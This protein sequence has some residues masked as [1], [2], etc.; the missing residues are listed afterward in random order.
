MRLILLI[1]LCLALV[2]AS[3]QSFVSFGE[4]IEGHTGVPRSDIRRFTITEN[5]IVGFTKFLASN[6]VDIVVLNGDFL[7]WTDKCNTCSFDINNKQKIPKCENTWDCPDNFRRV[8]SVENKMIREARD[9]LFT[10]GANTISTLWKQQR[11]TVVK[12]T[13]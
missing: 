7:T 12:S 6:K 1:A 8:V 9:V 11:H 3:S 2:S 5:S 4:F 10:N 13:Q